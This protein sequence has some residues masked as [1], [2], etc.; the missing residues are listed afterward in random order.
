MD[1]IIKM[2][3]ILFTC[4][5]PLLTWTS[6]RID[7]AVM[8]YIIDVSERGLRFTIT[9][10]RMETSEHLEI[11]TANSVKKT[12]KKKPSAYSIQG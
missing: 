7:M 5:D 4:D 10:M 3:H 9:L 8:L 12:P 2:C 1:F 6:G 11:I